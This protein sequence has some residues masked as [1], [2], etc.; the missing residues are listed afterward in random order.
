MMT[1]VQLTGQRTNITPDDSGFQGKSLA[2]HQVFLSTIRS[3]TPFPCADGTSSAFSSRISPAERL[4]LEGVS[5][6]AQKGRRLHKQE[7]EAVGDRSILRSHVL[8]CS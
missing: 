3:G 1:E 5:E 2:I 8:L 7:P 6:S 4:R